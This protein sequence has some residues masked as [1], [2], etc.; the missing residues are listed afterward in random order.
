V[1]RRVKLLS[2]LDPQAAAVLTDVFS[3]E[4]TTF[5]ALAK[6]AGMDPLL[7]FR[8]TDMRG[9]ELQDIDVRGVD[10]SG[11]DL[12]M[13]GF[14][15]SIH[16]YTTITKDAIFDGDK[17]TRHRTRNNEIEASELTLDWAAKTVLPIEFRNREVVL[18]ATAF[19]ANDPTL[20]AIA[21]IHRSDEAGI[22]VP[23]VGLHFCCI[24]GDVFHSLRCD[25]YSQLR[26]KLDRI[27]AS[28][29]GVL[30]YFPFREGFALGG[31]ARLETISSGN[32]KGL[33]RNV[34]AGAL[35]FDLAAHILFDLGYPEVKLLANS[36]ANVESLSA[37][38]VTVVEQLPFST[39]VPKKSKGTKR[40]KTRGLAG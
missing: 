23:I 12:R 25:C 28:P 10:F 29:V 33:V 26:V 4:A 6:A 16:D 8:N 36:Q 17:Q 3:S 13:T 14:S 34:A 9:W 40:K 22:G 20:Q 30:I 7:D 39:K 15:Q 2:G 1:N 5:A 35:E 31:H 24:T 21:F 32:G 18:E 38:G 19:Q 37:E 11:A 27:I